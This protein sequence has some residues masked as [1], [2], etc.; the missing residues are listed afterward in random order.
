M[1]LVAAFGVAACESSPS[2][3]RVAEDL[4]NTMA[5]DDPVVRDCMLAIIETDYPDDTLDKIGEGVEDGD[6]EAIAALEEFESAL[7]SCR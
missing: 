5:A 2:A 3:R 6:P 4:V 7:S 1:A